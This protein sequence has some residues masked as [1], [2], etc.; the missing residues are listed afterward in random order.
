MPASTATMT[1]SKPSG[2]RPAGPPRP[3]GSA[4]AA[5]RSRRAPTHDRRGPAPARWSA[6]G[7]GSEGAAPLPVVTESTVGEM[8]PAARSS[9]AGSASKRTRWGSARQRGGGSTTELTSAAAPG[10]SLFWAATAPA[11][12]TRPLMLS[13]SRL[14]LLDCD[15]LV[16]APR[17][18]RIAASDGARCVLRRAP[19]TRSRASMRSRSV[20]APRETTAWLEAGVGEYWHLVGRDFLDGL[21]GLVA[22]PVGCL[23]RLLVGCLVRLLV[24]VPG[25]GQG[26]GSRR[27][28]LAS[29]FGGVGEAVDAHRGAG[30]LGDGRCGGRDRRDR[31]GDRRSGGDCRR[32]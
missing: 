23:V 6:A 22:A 5:G 3:R 29:V 30:G 14:W 31:H 12:T 9:S 4:P 11:S 27:F 2:A 18:R 17:S 8:A 7:A 19:R 1:R 26:S 10:A 13:K 32:G 15:G 20:D 28:F 21:V 25:S 24:H 16:I